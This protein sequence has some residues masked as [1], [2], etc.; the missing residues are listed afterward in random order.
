MYRTKVTDLQDLKTRIRN[1]FELVIVEMLE[2]TWREIEY[3]LDVVRATRG[4]H[5]DVYE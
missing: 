1:A 4:A 2:R 3:R 5:I